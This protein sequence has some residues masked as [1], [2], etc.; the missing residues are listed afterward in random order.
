MGS[1]S[2]S[3]RARARGAATARAWPAPLALVPLS[4]SLTLPGAPPVRRMPGASAA[5]TGAA[6]WTPRDPL[7]FLAAGRLVIDE[8]GAGDVVGPAADVSDLA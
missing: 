2:G 5:L 3:G 1:C 7:A 4:L 8:A 6:A